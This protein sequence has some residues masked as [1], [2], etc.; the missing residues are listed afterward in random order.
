MTSEQNK[1]VFQNKN[2]RNDY[3][4]EHKNWPRVVLKMF[5]SSTSIDVLPLSTLR[6]DD[7]NK[8]GDGRD[9]RADDARPTHVELL[10]DTADCRR[11]HPRD[12]DDACAEPHEH[13]DVVPACPFE[14]HICWADTQDGVR[15]AERRHG[16][17]EKRD[18]CRKWHHTDRE[19]LHDRR[20]QEKARVVTVECRQVADKETRDGSDDAGVRDHESDFDWRRAELV[21]HERRDVRPVDDDGEAEKETDEEDVP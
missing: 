12:R 17:D 3:I 11:S 10:R 20:M 18:A 8:Y 7:L 6:D 5:I 2:K 14:R 13:A 16:D 1:Q 4:P 9:R 21:V 19:G 15:D